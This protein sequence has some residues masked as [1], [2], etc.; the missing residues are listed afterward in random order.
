M[1]TY[2]SCSGQQIN[3]NKT[4]ILVDLHPEEK[5]QLIKIAL[6]V[7][8]IKS[9]EKYLGLPSLV[10]KKKKASFEYIKEK[11]W[12]KLKGWEEESLSQA[13]REILI[14]DFVQTIPTYIMNCFKLPLGL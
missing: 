2:G 4:T 8:K 12:R 14:K 13:E 3:K 9:F 7:P 1:E 11:V 6:G 10:G 5:R